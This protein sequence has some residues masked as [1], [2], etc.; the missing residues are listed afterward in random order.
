MPKVINLDIHSTGRC[1]DTEWLSL[2]QYVMAFHKVI[3]FRCGGS[4]DS[5]DG[6][7][8]DASA[9][10]N[11]ASEGNI[12]CD[13]GLAKAQGHAATHQHVLSVAYFNKNHIAAKFDM[14][15]GA[16]Q[17]LV[18]AWFPIQFTKD[19][20]VLRSN[21]DLVNV[22]V[23]TKEK[24]LLSQIMFCCHSIAGRAQPLRLPFMTIPDTLSYWSLDILNLTKAGI[25]KVRRVMSR[26][27]TL[28]L[29]IKCSSFDPDLRLIL[30]HALARLRRS[31][32]LSLVL[33]GEAVGTWLELLA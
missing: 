9:N 14:S 33:H 1:D 27:R 18:S 22:A 21:P 15:N 25:E 3:G 29:T 16:F 7:D 8:D 12:E 30:V 32:L 10:N 17:G 24:D 19:F 2:K 6:W 23:Q 20:L 11:S 26:S 5:R 4:G 31:S 13:S 28:S